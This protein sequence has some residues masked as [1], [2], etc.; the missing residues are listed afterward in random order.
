MAGFRS[1]AQRRKWSQLVSEGTVTQDQFAVRELETAG[2]A[3]PE[4]TKPRRRTVGPSRAP[5][6][7]KI[8]NT[9]Y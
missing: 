2:V 4:R 3:L 8:N 9:R 5:D 1:E 7:A 6:A